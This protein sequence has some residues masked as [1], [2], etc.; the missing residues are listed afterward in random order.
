MIVPEEIA[1]AEDIR[2]LQEL[3]P[4]FLTIEKDHGPLPIWTRPAGFE[5]LVKLI[6]EQQVSLASAAAHYKKLREFTGGISPE[7]LH[8]ISDEDFRSCHISRQ[9]TLYIKGLSAAILSKEFNL[10]ELPQLEEAEARIRLKKLK[11]IGDWTTD[12]YLMFCLKKKDIFPIGDIALF[13]TIKEFYGL[14]EKEAMVKFSDKWAPYRSLATHFFWHH[15]LCSR[16]RKYPTDHF[17]L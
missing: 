12:V 11:G 8:N 17:D 14:T 15:Y 4:I 6:L 13:N 3:D 16:N 9:K 7:I 1:N 2:R 10:E 5:S